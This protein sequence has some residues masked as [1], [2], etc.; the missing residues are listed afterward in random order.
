MKETNNN[1]P[2][3]LHLVCYGKRLPI[4]FVKVIQ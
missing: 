4:V 3:A 2:V 1:K